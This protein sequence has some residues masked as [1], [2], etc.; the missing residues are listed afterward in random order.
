M[1]LVASVHD[2]LRDETRYEIFHSVKFQKTEPVYG[3]HLVQG[4]AIF[5]IKLCVFFFP[6]LVN[7]CCNKNTE[8][9]CILI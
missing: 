1:T 4:Q 2:G 3:Y 5:N 8:N 6:Y 9:N 7:R